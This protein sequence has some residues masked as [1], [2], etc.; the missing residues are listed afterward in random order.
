MLLH[1]K[2]SMIDIYVGYNIFLQS[3]AGTAVLA[4]ETANLHFISDNKIN[5]LAPREIT[6]FKTSVRQ[7][8]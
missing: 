2:Y 1:V 5:L 6:K 7:L 8:F 4:C 3:F